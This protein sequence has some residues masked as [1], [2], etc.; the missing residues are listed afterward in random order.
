MKQVIQRGLKGTDLVMK[1]G[2]IDKDIAK[3]D[4]SK[5]TVP[6]I[7]RLL[8]KYESVFI[9]KDDKYYQID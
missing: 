3:F 6:Q 8:E 1:G 4:H 5:I 9:Q 2:I 7:E